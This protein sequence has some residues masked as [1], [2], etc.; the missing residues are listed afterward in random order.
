MS[1]RLKV[2]VTHLPVSPANASMAATLSAMNTMKLCKSRRS[3]SA[4]FYAIYSKS[5][6]H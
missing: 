3:T 6:T 4:N 5:K 1:T 2:I